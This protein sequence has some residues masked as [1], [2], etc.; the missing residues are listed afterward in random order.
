MNIAFSQI[1]SL[2][3]KET[4]SN[5]GATW[6]SKQN[7]TNSI[8]ILCKFYSFRIPIC[9]RMLHFKNTNW[10]SIGWTNLCFSLI[11]HSIKPR[12]L[13]WLHQFLRETKPQT[14]EL[15]SL[16][17]V[18]NRWLFPWYLSCDNPNFPVNLYQNPNYLKLTT[19]PLHKFKTQLSSWGN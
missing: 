4:N 8:L 3:S 10:I 7:L 18:E 15:Q 12:P 6:I 1:E 9:C 16:K 11:K 14:L 2:I 17:A 5:R 13:Y 19:S